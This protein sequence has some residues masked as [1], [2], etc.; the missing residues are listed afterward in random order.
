VDNPVTEEDT[1]KVASEDNK[2]PT[3]N[4][5]DPTVEEMLLT[6]LVNPEVVRLFFL[7]LINVH[8]LEEY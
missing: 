1:N 5:V 6:E 4:K 3:V 2:V 8:L 7:S